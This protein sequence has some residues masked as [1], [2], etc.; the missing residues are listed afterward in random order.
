MTKYPKLDFA[1]LKE[2]EALVIIDA[3]MLTINTNISTT[4]GSGISSPYVDAAELES[5][6]QPFDYFAKPRPYSEKPNDP[7]L[8]PTA[9]DQ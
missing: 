9:E 1:R 3:P 5:I 2:D 7:T 4:A 6:G 8:S